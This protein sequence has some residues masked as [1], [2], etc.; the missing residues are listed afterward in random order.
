[1]TELFGL[2]A[3][4]VGLVSY[5]PYVRDILRRATRPERTS[6]LIWTCEYGV[7]FFAQF[8]K[9]ARSA[10]WLIGLEFIGVTV[11]YALS[12]HYGTGRLDSRSGVLLGLVSLALILWFFTS[13]VSI[14]L[15]LT[16]AVETSGVLLTVIKAYRQPESES[17]PS[18]LLLGTA[19]LVDI[20]AVGPAAPGIL[21]AYPISLILMSAS[22]VGASLLGMRLASR[23]PEMAG[24]LTGE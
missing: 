6:W 20:P 19:G 17:L 3:G 12:L 1:M 2:L 5:V 9:G 16:L 4:T 22:V 18:W 7:L 11:I 10:L 13:N 23:E 8:A 21:Y 14:A 24:L 15:L